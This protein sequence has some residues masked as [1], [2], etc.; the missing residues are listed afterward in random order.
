MTTWYACHNSHTSWLPSLHVCV[1]SCYVQLLL[2]RG[3]SPTRLLC[4]WDSQGVLEW[5][6]ISVSR[7]DTSFLPYLHMLTPPHWGSN[8]LVSKT[9]FAFS[10]Q[11]ITFHHLIIFFLFPLSTYILDISRC[12]VS[13]QSYCFSVFPPVHL[14]EKLHSHPL[15]IESA[16]P[17][18]LYPLQINQE[19]S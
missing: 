13:C 19:K 11:P 9:F 10:L 4:P 14:P 7:E 12:W 17:L 2:S 3:L 6:V 5:V 18:L 1:L 16:L 8:V 15:A